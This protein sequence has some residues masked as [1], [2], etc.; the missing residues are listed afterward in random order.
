[1]VFK[2]KFRKFKKHFRRFSRSFKKWKGKRKMKG[3]KMTVANIK[4]YPFSDLTK[5]KMSYFEEFDLTVGVSTNTNQYW[6]GNTLYQPSVSTANSHQPLGFDQWMAF[7]GA[8]HVKASS[9][10]VA[11]MNRTTAAAPASGHVIVFPSSAA[12]GSIQI[13]GFSPEQPYVKYRSIGYSDGNE[14]SVHLKHYMTNKKQM[15]KSSRIDEAEIG[16]ATANPQLQ[17]YWNIDI[18]NDNANNSLTV[19]VLVWL[20]FYA[21]LFDRKTV[22]PS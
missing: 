4:G 17:W 6:I 22:A 1:M 5:I 12:L 8:F 11:V 14:G 9:I 2:R 19:K 20:K 10:K 13:N 7:Y 21:V 18:A 15:G 3:R 16:T